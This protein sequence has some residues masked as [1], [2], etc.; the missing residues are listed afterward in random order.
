MKNHDIICLLLVVFYLKEEFCMN[1]DDLFSYKVLS[2]A[3]MINIFGGAGKWH[4][5]GIGVY[6][7]GNQVCTNWNQAWHAVGRIS[8][9]S[10]ANGLAHIR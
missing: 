7:K 2:E 8:Y 6:T 4:Y 5:W 1:F 9:G 3:E 10:W